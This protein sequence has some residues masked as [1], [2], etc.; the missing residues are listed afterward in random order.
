M[1]VKSIIQK[2]EF[3]YKKALGQN[4]ITDNSLLQAIVR[5]AEITENDTV[6][7][8][9]TGAGTLTRAIA[10][11]AKRVISFDVDSDLQNILAETLAGLENVEVI[12]RD[13][14]KMKDEELTEIIGGKFKVVANLPYYITTPMVM[15]FMD[16]ALPVESLTVMV[17][18]EVAERITANAGTS[19]YG[20]ITVSIR[21][22][23]D[24]K[25]TRIV[26]R[27][28]FFP[29]P[30]VDSAVLH[31]KMNKNKY[32]IADEKLL[33]R[34]IKCGFAMRR[35]TLVNNL[36]MAF[37]FSKEDSKSILQECGH[38]ERI[39]GEVLSV[40]QYIALA[41]SINIKLPK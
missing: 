40:E 4:F 37:N 39:R 12:F 2:H 10:Q 6:V 20:A 34:T 23:A 14:L 32:N 38:D 33:R 28:L 16:S 27:Q 5:D 35:K 17:Q 9:G 24:V 19:D 8:I 30:K 3:R 7:E 1:E 18:K 26:G 41:E 21:Y 36:S 15:R 29:Q 13:V 25:V 11:K 22:R 31:I